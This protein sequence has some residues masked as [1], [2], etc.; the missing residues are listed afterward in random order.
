MTSGVERWVPISLETLLRSE[1]FLSDARHFAA[2]PNVSFEAALEAVQA[3]EGFLGSRR[4]RTIAGTVIANGEQ[5]ASFTNFVVNFS[6]LRRDSAISA[7]TL[8]EAIDTN[9]P[10]TLGPERT[11]VLD[12]TVKVL[13]PIPGLERQAKVEQ[14][15]RRTGAHLDELALIS[16][17][18]PIFDPGGEQ[19]EGLVPLT[20]L[21]LVTHRAGTL[22]R[23]IVEVHITEEELDD[24]CAAAERAKRKLSV[25]KKLV[26]A[27][28][29]IAL[30]ESVMT[31][32]ET[33]AA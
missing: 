17:L 3:A 12:R 13:A 25:L 1:A 22:E 10:E 14:V 26:A 9:L 19:V 5:A 16:D 18:R 2:I 33:P 31:L 32:L 21:K 6:Q 29:D 30:P 11:V 24:L 7:E 28:K 8:I 20:T 23:S 27:Q 15:V 4:L